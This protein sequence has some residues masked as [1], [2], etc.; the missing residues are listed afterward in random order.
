M[1]DPKRGKGGGGE[2]EVTC[3]VCKERVRVKEKDAEKSM[4]VR[5][6]KGHEIPLVRMM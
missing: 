5:C 4:T 3:P 1:D 6:S 2:I